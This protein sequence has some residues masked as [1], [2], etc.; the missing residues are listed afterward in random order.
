MM[1]MVRNSTTPL[2]LKELE[3]EHVEDVMRHY[4]YDE[5]K[6]A[7]ALDITLEELKS[8]LKAYGGYYGK[9]VP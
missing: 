2:T 5:E 7:W 6:A 3:R 1:S 8:K 4:S 9:A